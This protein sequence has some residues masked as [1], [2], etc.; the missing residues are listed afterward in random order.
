MI[1]EGFD[2]DFTI[3]DR[4]LFRGNEEQILEA[5]AVMTVVA[6]EIMYQKGGQE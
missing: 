3:F 1:L 6:G 2:A 5:Q 4:D